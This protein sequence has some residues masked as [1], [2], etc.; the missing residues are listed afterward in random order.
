MFDPVL[1]AKLKKISIFLIVYTLLFVGFFSTIKYTLPFVLAFLIA[2]LMKPLTEFFKR[3]FHMSSGFSSL[4]STIISF[5]LITLILVLLIMKVATESKD[6]LASLPSIDIDGISNYFMLKFESLKHFYENLDPTIIT[7]IKAQIASI[8]SGIIAVVKLLLDKLIVLAMSLPLI[9]MVILVTLLATFFISKDLP[10]IKR[11]C[12]SSL[13][14]DGQEKFKNFISEANKMLFQYIK[15]YGIII[16]ITF[17]LT[18][19]G[20]SILEIE[21]S[22]MLS[23]LSGV[24]DLLPILGIAAVYFPLAIYYWIIGNHAVAIILVVLYA[25]V[26]VVRNIVEPKLVSSSLN[27]HPV[28]VLAAIFIGLQAYGFLGM[29]FLIFLMLFYNI[30]KKVNVL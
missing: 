24:L 12:L 8:T 15:S 19:I 6:I 17:V 14:P 3:K 21:Y 5:S 29:I 26:T 18:W 2:F 28:A 16:F 1:L 9:I 30:L 25:V 4:I 23:L 13:S 11:K 20:F 7:Q 22:F 27:L 10:A